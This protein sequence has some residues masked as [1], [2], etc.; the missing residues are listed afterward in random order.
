VKGSV[1]VEDKGV[2]VDLIFTARNEAGA[3]HVKRFIEVL[4]DNTVDTGLSALLRN[5][6]VEATSSTL[7]V[8]W[9]LPPEI[10]MRALSE[11]KARPSGESAPDAAS[12]EKSEAPGSSDEP[13]PTTKTKPSSD[14]APTK[15]PKNR[16]PSSPPLPIPGEGLR[17]SPPPQLE[18]P[19]TGH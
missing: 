19:Q 8:K 17:L 14:E 1:E 6:D 11:R 12:P 9:V 5:I 18:P 7:H 13:A 16:E 15:R 2:A 4:R 3:T 10:V